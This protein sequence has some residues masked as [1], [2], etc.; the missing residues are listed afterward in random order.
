M[1]QTSIEAV[2][3]KA[4]LNAEFREALLANPDDALADFNLSPAEKARLKRMDCEAMD[5]LARTLNMPI[6]KGIARTDL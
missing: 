3:G 1:S 6:H 2:I 4:I 5:A